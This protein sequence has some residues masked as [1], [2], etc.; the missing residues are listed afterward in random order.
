VLLVLLVL[1]VILVP[2]VVGLGLYEVVFMLR[3]GIS[4]GVQLHPFLR[5]GLSPVLSPVLL[6]NELN[7]TIVF[8]FL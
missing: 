7:E 5:D 4:F 8:L 1:L 3:I 2:V 6:I